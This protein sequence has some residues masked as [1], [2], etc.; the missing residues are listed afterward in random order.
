MNAMPEFPHVVTNEVEIP[1]GD[2]PIGLTIFRPLKSPKAVVVIN[3]A[4]GV[5][6]T[7]YR[8]FAQWLVTNNQIACVTY[9]YHD[10][11]ASA[12]HHVKFSKATMS[13]WGIYDQQAAR[14]LTRE[15]FPN[16]PL[17]V[18]GHSLGG[19]MLPFQ[20]GLDD[21]SRF[22]AV[23]SGPIH[24][25]EHPFPYQFVARIFWSRPLLML[26]NILG[27]MPG[28]SLGLG[29]NIPLGVY[30]EWRRWCTTRGFFNADLGRSLPYPDFGAL[31]C[32]S[33][34]VSLSDDDLVPSSAVWRL[35]QFYPRAIKKQLVLKPSD[36]GL[37]KV[38][39]IEVFRKKNKALWS[40][41]IE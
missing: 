26:S 41:I 25:S 28:Q 39:H 24:V 36:F 4:T 21:V 35:M 6:Q 34:F 3:P 9:D 22:I 2:K 10:F 33:K 13:R 30:K 37:G 11:G 18:I 15:I 16:V 7:Y 8:K 5:P 1:S 17:W 32:P 12:R 29:P 23:N 14:D 20:S 38:G 40:K 27:Y 31:K 19:F